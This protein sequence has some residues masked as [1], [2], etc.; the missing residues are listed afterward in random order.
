MNSHKIP[1][2]DQKIADIVNKIGLEGV[3]AVGDD[4][5]VC[6]KVSGSKERV[7]EVARIISEDPKV[8][9]ASA[10]GIG[11]GGQEGDLWINNYELGLHG[12]LGDFLN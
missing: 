10:N 7:E 11:D 2:N 12:E 6:I 9:K 8:Q 1:N 4:G 3:E 5:S